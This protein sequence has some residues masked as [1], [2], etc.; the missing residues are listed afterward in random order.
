MLRE[1]RDAN[2]PTRF[3]TTHCRL[4]RRYVIAVDPEEDE[5]LRS[6]FGDEV[7]ADDDLRL[8]LDGRV[9]DVNVLYADEY[10]VWVTGL[11]PIRDTEGNVVAAAAADLPAIAGRAGES[12]TADARASFASMLQPAVVRVSR[13]ELDAITDGLT[14]LY[15]HRYLHERLHE[16]LERARRLDCPL[17][18]LICDLDQFAEYNERS[19]YSAG[20]EA[21]RDVAH[22]IEESV[23][24]ID[25]AARY[26]GEEFAVALVDTARTART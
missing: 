11:A 1:V 5:S 16:E 23:R 4:D 8:T 17:A 26:S 25:I 20:D 13:I 6:H 18:V 14:G 3:L 2:P 22:I 21:L 24:T 9:P 10:G 12:L 7:F 15:N 19:G